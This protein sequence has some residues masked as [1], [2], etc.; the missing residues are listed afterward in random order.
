MFNRYFAN[1]DA[2]ARRSINSK[3][4]H[5]SQ[6]GTFDIQTDIGDIVEIVTFDSPG[7][8]DFI[9]NQECVDNIKDYVKVRHEQWRAL[10]PQSMTEAE[11]LAADNRIHCIFYFIAPHRMKK[12]DVEFIK[13]LAPIVPIVPIIAKADTMTT[14]E[15]N[16]Y[17]KS[18]NESLQGISTAM[19]ESCVYDFTVMSLHISSQTVM[20]LHI[21]CHA[22]RWRISPWF[23]QQ[24][25]PQ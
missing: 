6:I 16:D 24:S 22:G 23:K 14:F 21:N 9:N 13:Q 18:V 19:G 17:L 11:F 3:T 2:K 4:S 7:Y 1:I 8:G 25:T 5:I 12:L 15:R 20:Y 10:E